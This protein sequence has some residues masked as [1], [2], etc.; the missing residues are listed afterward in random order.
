MSFSLNTNI[1]AMQANLHSNLN[2]NATSKTLESLSSGS[3]IGSA[4]YDAS[5]LGISNQLSAQVSGLGQAIQNSNESIG[6]IQI[7]DGA[8]QGIS[9]NMERIRV[10]TLQASNGTMNADNRAIIQKEIDGL[11]D[12]SDDIAKQTSY[13]GINLLNGTGG[14]SSDG[15]FVTQTGASAG[16]TSTMNIGDAQVA[17]L[18][19]SIDVTTQAGREEAL[20][21]IDSAMQGIGGIR[22]ELGASQ[23]QL[24]SNIRNTSVTQINVA[25]AESQI[26]DVDFALESAN[27]SR[28]NIMSQVGSF[29]QAQANASGANIT[30]LFS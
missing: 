23:N 29:A 16:D 19:G 9:D 7:A 30:R 28:Q 5:G 2:S 15:S 13:N 11:L 21:S 22:S 3:Q 1:G 20:D 8:M 17:S 14:S 26:R 25:S 27:F 12:S 24:M 4:S 10:L 18:V 6:M